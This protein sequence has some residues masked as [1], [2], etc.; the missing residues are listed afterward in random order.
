MVGGEED[1]AYEVKSKSRKV[2]KQT[3]CR[4]TGAKSYKESVNHVRNVK[5]SPPFPKGYLGELRC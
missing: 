5:G 3:P 4:D 2:E 1:G